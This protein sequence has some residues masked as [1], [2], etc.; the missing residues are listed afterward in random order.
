MLL[1]DG[2]MARKRI[3]IVDP[4]PPVPTP[5]TDLTHPPTVIALTQ[6]LYVLEP[7]SEED[8]TRVLDSARSY[9]LVKPT[10]DF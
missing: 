5:L 7:L 3:P 8:R 6:V 10:R 2:R 9:F 4:D 1:H